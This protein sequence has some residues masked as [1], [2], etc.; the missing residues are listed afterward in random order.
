MNVYKNVLNRGVFNF[1]DNKIHNAE[2]IVADVS[3]NK[4][5]LS[6]KIKA[7]SEKPQA[8]NDLSDNNLIVMPYN[9]NNRFSSENISL[10]IPEGALYDTLD[11]SY[12]K[13]TGTAFMLSDLHYVHNKFTPLNKSCRLSIKPTSIPAGKETKMLIVLLDDDQKKTAVKSTWTEGYLSADILSFGKYF[14]GIDTIAPVISAIGSISGA[15][16]TGK[17]E[18][19]IKVTD[20]LSGIKSYEPAIDGKWAL[21]EY[22]QKNDVLIY[23][24]DEKRITKGSNH[25]LFLKV[26]DNKNNSSSFNCNFTW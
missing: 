5:S 4:S 12:K 23:K 11:F 24:F 21:F 13:E 2:I 26:T 14:V 20:E 1:N 10:Y 7:Q 16:L 8:V 9:R 25:V 15:T 19:R 3:N 22:D 18:L 17:K 6:F